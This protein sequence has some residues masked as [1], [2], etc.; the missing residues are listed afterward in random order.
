M[1]KAKVGII[2]VNYKDY[3]S[4]FLFDFK[5]SLATQD[6]GSNNFQVYIIDNAASSE[7]L[8]L[9][10][11][12]YKEAEIIPRADG[13][14]CAANNLGFRRAILDG[15]K[16]VV[17]V[18]MDTEVTPNWLTELV[19]ALEKNPKAG[20]VQS[21]VLLYNND[22][23]DARIN[24]LGNNL[25][26]LGFGTT[27]YYQEKDREI[28]GYPEI[29]GYASGCCFIA[30]REVFSD[31]SGW[32]EDYFMYHDDIEFSLKAK[33]KN[34]K[35]I[36]APKSVIYHKYEFAR[37]VK[38][39]Y[40]MERNRHLLIFHFFPIRLL[41]FVLPALI[42]M[43]FGMLF[44]SFIGRWFTTWLKV[45]LYFL[46]PKH[47]WQIFVFRRKIKR[48]GSISSYDFANTL[49]AR[50]EFLE[51]DNLLLRRIGNPLLVLYWRLVKKLI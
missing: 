51:I 17:T 35:I 4:R 7:S 16:Y 38:M 44:Y 5:K 9:L 42:I 2:L 6:Y 39:L 46:H 1:E 22:S 31:I 21:K 24:T 37:S 45:N 10:N 33:L 3:A 49:I 48:L 43:N 36:L 34:Y 19:R 40:F 27:S 29:K 28:E 13:N 20:I 47:I 32:N 12:I 11:K 50:L 23:Q 25:H 8:R 15:C 14:Y 30:R 18:N 41:L 26:F